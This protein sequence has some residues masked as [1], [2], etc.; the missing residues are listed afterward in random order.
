MSTWAHWVRA[1]GM[2]VAGSWVPAT[3]A[4]AVV[5]FSVDSTLDQL[6]DDT[7]EGV[8]HTAANTCTLRK[9]GLLELIASIQKESAL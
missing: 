4:S 9:K 2:S 6:D 5:A 7:A 3:G 8:C 1:L